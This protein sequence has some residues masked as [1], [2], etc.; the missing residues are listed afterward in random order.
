MAMKKKM[1]KKPMDGKP[2]MKMTPA[3]VKE[4]EAMM[5]KGMSK[6]AA[7]AAVHKRGTGKK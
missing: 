6:S 7:M 4:M 1:G 3:M 2:M 5:A